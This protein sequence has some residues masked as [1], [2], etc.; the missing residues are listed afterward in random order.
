LVDKLNTQKN[1]RVDYRVLPGAD[2]VFAAQA[3]VIGAAIEDHVG[4]AIA[5]RAMALAAD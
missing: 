2:H 5:R 1:D 3:E 4:K